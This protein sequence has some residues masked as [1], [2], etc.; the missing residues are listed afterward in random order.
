VQ[1]DAFELDHIKQR[2]MAPAGAQQRRAVFMTSRIAT[3][4][5]AVVLS[6]GTTGA[7]ALASKDS[8]SGPKGGA[9]SGQYWPG[10]GCGDQNH[11]HQVSTDKPCPQDPTGGSGNAGNQGNGKNGKGH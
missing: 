4:A 9:A 2:V 8:S 1:A 5:T 6:V 3:L 11:D 10:K 7:I